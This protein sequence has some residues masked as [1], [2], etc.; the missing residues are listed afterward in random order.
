VGRPQLETLCNI[1]AAEIIMPVGSLPEAEIGALSIEHLL[2]LRRQ[3]EVSMEA[4]LNRLVRVTDEPLAMFCASRVHGDGADG[5]YRIEY[6]IGS[7]LW[8]VNTLRGQ[9]LPPESVVAQCTAIGMAGSEDERWP[10]IPGYVGVRCVAVQPHPGDV[11]PRVVGLLIAQR[12]P[13]AVPSMEEVPGNA[14]QPKRTGAAIIAHVVN[15]R[16]PNWGGRGFAQALRGVYPGVQEEFRLWV[17]R[18]PSNLKLGNVHWVRVDNRLT[19]A[20]MVAQ[21]GYGES[22]KPRLRY[23]ALEAC[24]D[25]VAREARERGAVVHM[26][27][28]GT[29]AAGGDWRVIQGIID[30]ALCRTGVRVI[31]YFLPSTEHPRR[32]V[33]RTGGGELS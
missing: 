7:H 21:A 17:A 29:G 5:R 20:S 10:F 16:T 28:I 30:G 8:S 4:L 32:G 18:Q 19:V 27:R 2:D 6:A 26:P 22:S 3:Y 24:L 15:D 12:T 31:V 14:L 1:A 11:Y 9:V 33:A 25:E 13:N 23:Q